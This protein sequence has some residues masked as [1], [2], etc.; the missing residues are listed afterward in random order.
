M[1]SYIKQITVPTG[2]TY[3]IKDSSAWN[4][5]DIHDTSIR[6]LYSII[7][8][9]SLQL[10]K[11]NSLSN[12]PTA[13]SDTL[14]KIYL[15]PCN[16]HDPSVIDTSVKDIFDEYVTV[17]GG[18]T[19]NP[20]YTW[21]KIGNT[22]VNL[23][24]YA[25]ISHTH[26]VIGTAE[27]AGSHTHTIS[28]TKKYL[29]AQSNVP[30]SFG[31]GTFVTG[32]STSKLVTT[33]ISAVKAG[34]NTASLASAGTAVKVAKPGTEK[35]YSNITENSAGT[36]T[37]TC[38]SAATGTG[39]LTGNE[40]SSRGDNTPMYGATVSGE[41]LSFTFKAME[42]ANRVTGISS[43]TTTATKTVYSNSSITG[44]NG[45]VNYTPYTFTPVNIPDISTVT[46]A[47][48]SV[49]SSGSGSTIATGSSGTATAYNAINSSVSLL[50]NAAPA[51]TATNVQV[52]TN[53]TTTGSDGAHTHTLDATTG[54]AI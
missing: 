28:P 37:V 17:V 45:S 48:G 38:S 14:G 23:G 29:Q 54:P 53:V 42:T 33:S 50:K 9:G 21:E 52:V 24:N 22:D 5:I 1:P 36:V 26:N 15:V 27:S 51:N 43:A 4:T 31:T 35:S 47:T 40:L 49:S 3:N 11:V 7:N 12:L 8:Q 44:I 18:T 25:L 41:V 39:N 10:V 32:V 16:Q 30:L 2:T 13:S 46:V 34:S 19:Q 20:V 6:N